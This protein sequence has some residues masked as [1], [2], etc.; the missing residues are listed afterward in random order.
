[1]SSFWSDIAIDISMKRPGID[2]SDD[3]LPDFPPVIS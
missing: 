3:L 2:I 1:M